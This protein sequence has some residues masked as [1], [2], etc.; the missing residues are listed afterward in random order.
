MMLIL[1]LSLLSL[2]IATP[3]LLVSGANMITC[4][5]DVQKLHCETGLIIVKSSL[6][7]RTDSTTCSTNRPPAQVAVTT[8]SLPITTIGDRCNGL[9]DCELKTDLLGNTDPCQGTY[10]YYNTSFDCI[11]GNYAVICEHGYSTLDCGN[12]AILIVNANYGRASSQ[13]CSNG[14]PN[15]LTQNTNCYAANTLTTVA[16]L[17]NG[18]KSCTVEALNTIFSDPCS[19]TVKYLTVTYICTKEMVVCEGGSASINCGAQTIKTIWAN[20]GRTDSTVCSTGR[21][22]SQLLN[23]NCYTS[24]TL[25]KVAAGCDHLST[26]TIPANNNFFGDPCPNTYKYLRIVYACV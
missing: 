6:Y 26:C 22:G 19:G 1:K 9:P 2:L 17:C 8:C 3:G 24:D 23:T 5:G 15:G 14:L 16:G 7:G 11:N 4:Y 12:D 10:K 20:Y 21:P 25:N 18:K 13:I